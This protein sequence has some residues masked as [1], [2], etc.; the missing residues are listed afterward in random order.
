VAEELAGRGA[1]L[2]LL[3]RSEEAL[4]Q[5][6]ARLPHSSIG[7]HKVAALD[8]ADGTALQSGVSE[9]L[10][11][12]GTIDILINNTGGPKGGPLT[13]AQPE[14]FAAAF[15]HHVVATQI[16][17]SALLPGMTQQRWGRIINVLSTSVRVPIPGLGV[18]NTIRAAMAGYAKTLSAE[19]APH[20]I[21]VNNVLPGYTKTERLTALAAEASAR[22]NQD[23]DS[24]ES[25]WL[26]NVPMKRFG[27][28]AEVA[29]AIGFFASPMAGY[30]TGQSLAVDGGRIGAI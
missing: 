1:R 9:L 5:L 16:L 3:A 24:I 26:A 14:A 29:A 6:A 11:E 28:A 23:V 4:S 25:Q 10:T 20:G 13:Q 27:E 18:S 21:T 2:V 19:V 22:Q 30:I 17:V 8:M 12:L 7:K 15:Q